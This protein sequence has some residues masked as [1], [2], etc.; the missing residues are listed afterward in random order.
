MKKII[1]LYITLFASLCAVAQIPARPDPPKLVNDFAGILDDNQR[2]AL[3]NWLVAFNDSTS[4]QIVVV[5]VKDLGNYD[6]NQFAYE[7]GESWGVGQ[8]GKNNGVVV[9]V[10]PKTPDSRG[11]AAIQTGYGLEDVLPDAICRRIIDNEAIPR[12]KNNDYFGGITV[13][14][15]TVMDITKG[16]YTADQYTKKSAKKRNGGGGGALLVIII[17]V[18]IFAVIGSKNKNNRQNIGRRGSDLPLWMLMGGLGGS[19]RSSGWGS[20]SSGSGGFGG[21]GGGSFGGGGASGSW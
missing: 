10:K 17:L 6:A 18:I 2:Q 15:K 20:F 9:L 3:E 12:F 14:V 8:K 21:F 13:A 7:I 4:T 19:S 5:T 11:G 1:L 16:K